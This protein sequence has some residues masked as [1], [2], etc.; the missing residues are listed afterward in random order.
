MT[1]KPDYRRATNAAYEELKSYK[2]AYP[3]VD[4]LQ[5]LKQDKSICVMTYSELAKRAQGRL[6]LQELKK[7]NKDIKIK[8]ILSPTPPVECLSTTFLFNDDKSIISPLLIITS[9]K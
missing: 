5:L 3:V 8:V 2:G 1:E 9:V 4:I 7:Q 6:A